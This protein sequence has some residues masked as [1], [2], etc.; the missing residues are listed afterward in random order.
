MP[1]KYYK[2]LISINYF[3]INKTKRLARKPLLRGV[4]G[5]FRAHELTGIMGPSGAGKTTLLNLLAGYG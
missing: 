1:R 3:P 2:T 5:Q 4:Y